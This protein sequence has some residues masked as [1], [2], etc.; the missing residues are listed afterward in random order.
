MGDLKS[1]VSNNSTPHWQ[2]SPCEK[3]KE[4]EKQFKNINQISH[5]LVVCFIVQAC[6][7]TC[8]CCLTW[9]S[10][11]EESS[12]VHWTIISC[13]FKKQ[14]DHKTCL[15]E[16]LSFVMKEWLQQHLIKQEKSKQR[17]YG[18][19]K[20]EQNSALHSHVQGWHFTQQSPEEQT[21]TQ[22][23][24]GNIPKI[25]CWDYSTTLHGYH[26]LYIPGKDCNVQISRFSKHVVV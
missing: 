19:R 17:E 20:I 2:I 25:P 9:I 16:K 13:Q 1:A 14:D 21:S 15:P 3:E 4:N 7:F 23:R 26:S 11:M 18:R 10:H 6:K 22:S 8:M 12:Q 5:G 24:G